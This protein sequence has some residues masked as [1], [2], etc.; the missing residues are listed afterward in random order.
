MRE[1]IVHHLL[2]A[3]YK[4]STDN[5][6]R[7]LD[8]KCVQI[9]WLAKLLSTWHCALCIAVF[10]S[11]L[12]GTE[13]VHTYRKIMLRSFS[14]SKQFLLLETL[15]RLH[16][17]NCRPL[18]IPLSSSSELLCCTL[19]RIPGSRAFHTNFCQRQLKQK[20]SGRRNTLIEAKDKPFSELTLGEKGENLQ[21]C[22]FWRH[23]CVLTYLF[24]LSFVCFIKNFQYFLYFMWYLLF[25]DKMYQILMRLLL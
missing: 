17:V 20:D 9:D 24:L 15:T 3:V 11:V 22:A 5:N 23:S 13:R 14:Y 19:L 12:S 16:S 25:M 8:K 6:G 10:V 1:M 18:M 7:Q 4:I 2:F 21:I